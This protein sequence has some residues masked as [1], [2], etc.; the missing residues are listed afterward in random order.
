MNAAEVV[1]P[2]TPSSRPDDAEPAVRESPSQAIVELEE[3][4]RDA[5]RVG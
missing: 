3:R 1:E 2:E 4:R 5:Y